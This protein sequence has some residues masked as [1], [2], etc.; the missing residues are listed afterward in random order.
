MR[1]LFISP[2]LSLYLSRSLS[3]FPVSKKS[4]FQCG[5]KTVT[6]GCRNGAK[7]KGGWWRWIHHW[8]GE[9]GSVQFISPRVIYVLYAFMHSAVRVCL[10]SN[11]CVL[12]SFVLIRNLSDSL[13]LSQQTKTNCAPTIPVFT[14]WIFSTVKI[15]K[16]KPKI[17]FSQLISTIEKRKKTKT[18]K[19]EAKRTISRPTHRFR[20]NSDSRLSLVF[21]VLFNKALIEFALILVVLLPLLLPQ[22]VWVCVMSGAEQQQ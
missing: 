16:I 17:F 5:N 14:M 13:S 22:T 9:G 11:I 10:P 2:R 15:K 21:F 3:I 19:N 6:P 12:L 4:S 7:G 18:T 1:F 20:A 8:W